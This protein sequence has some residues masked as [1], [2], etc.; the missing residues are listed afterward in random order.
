MQFILSESVYN[1][2]ATARYQ[3]KEHTEHAYEWLT[4]MGTILNN[5]DV[6]SE[7]KLNYNVRT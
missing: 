3:Y 6:K 2:S 7:K 5:I 1:C 4:L